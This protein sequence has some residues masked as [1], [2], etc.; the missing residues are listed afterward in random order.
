M[1]ADSI[2]DYIKI[3]QYFIKQEGKLLAELLPDSII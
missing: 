3:S 1:A 2:S